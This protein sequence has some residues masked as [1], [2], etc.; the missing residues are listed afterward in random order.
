MRYVI[1]I[2]VFLLLIGCPRP[3]ED[4]PIPEINPQEN[5]AWPSLG[6]T[7]WPMHH[8]DPQSTGRSQYAG[9]SAGIIDGQFNAGYSVSGT[10]IGYDST[11]FVSSAYPPYAFSCFDYEGELKWESNFRSHSTPVIGSDSI[12]Y[13]GG[14]F[15]FYAFTQGGDTVWHRSLELMQTLGVNI[16]QHGNLYFIDDESNLIVVDNNGTSLW[17]LQDD[18]ILNDYNTAPSFSPDGQTLY[19]QGKTVSILA[20]DIN[21]RSV[22]WIFGEETLKSAPVVDN[23]GNIYFAPGIFSVRDK[24]RILYSINSDGEINW[25]YPF[26]AE[27]LYDNTEPT[28]DNDGNIIFA[29]DTLYCL[30]YRGSLRWKVGFEAGA[31]AFCPLISDANNV[32]YVGT[33]NLNIGGSRIRAIDASGQLLWSMTINEHIALGPGPSIAEDGTM[34][35]PTWDSG[36]PTVYIIK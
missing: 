18:R 15:S 5:I 19:V 20:V 32:V 10:T 30:D 7:P 1:P 2:M 28:I 14:E 36:P 27:W 8:H 31:Q 13:A 11:V 4:D 6:D 35:Y 34:F 29:T 33:L 24:H 9:P 26:V 23:A 22:K 16:D 25:V 21:S 17:Q 12:I 3:E